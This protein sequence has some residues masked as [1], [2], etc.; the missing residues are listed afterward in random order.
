MWEKDDRLFFKDH[1]VFKKR[2][3]VFLK[4]RGV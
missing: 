3:R 2:D 4:H 1:H